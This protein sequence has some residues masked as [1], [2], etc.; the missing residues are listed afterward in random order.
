MKKIILFLLIILV[1]AL[2]LGATLIITNKPLNPEDAELYYITGNA[3]YKQSDYEN[4]IKYYEKAVSINPLYE[5]VH[6]NLA[7][8]YN[9]L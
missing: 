4:A 1:P 5:E 2:V 9:K 8:L 3:L 7:F 6:N